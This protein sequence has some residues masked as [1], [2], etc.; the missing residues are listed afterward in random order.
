VK[1]SSLIYTLLL[2]VLVIGVSVSWQRMADWRD[3]ADRASADYR[4]CRLLA[5]R[6]NDLRAQRTVV[7]SQSL[8]QPEMSALIE[9]AARTA[10]IAVDQLDGIDPQTPRRAGRTAYERMPVR[11]TL[12]RSSMPQLIRFL[13]AVEEHETGLTTQHLAVTAP[14]DEPD[15]DL[16]K[17]DITFSYLLYNPAP[18]LT[19]APGGDPP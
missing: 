4:Q 8:A 18:T 15:P 19:A 3:H 17:T 16:W 1:R 9:Q 14:H 2:L 12:H 5:K 11:V 6:I 7:K 13:L 10:G